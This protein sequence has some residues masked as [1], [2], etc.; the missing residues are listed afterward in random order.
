MPSRSSAGHAAERASFSPN[1]MTTRRSIFSPR[2]RRLWEIRAVYL[3]LL[4][5]VK[6]RTPINLPRF[7]ATLG[8][9]RSDRH[10]DIDRHLP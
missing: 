2:F 5:W 4:W 1:P 8:Y 10:G 7:R 9:C 6:H 3:T